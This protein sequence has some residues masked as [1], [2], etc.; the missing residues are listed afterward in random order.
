MAI[1]AAASREPGRE[2]REPGRE[3]GRGP[4]EPGRDSREGRSSRGGRE[5]RDFAA[6]AAPAVPFLLPGESLGKYGAAAI[7]KPAPSRLILSEL[8]PDTSDPLPERTATRPS[9]LVEEEFAWD[10]KSLFPGESIAK[11]RGA[12]FKPSAAAQPGNEPSATVD[13]EPSGVLELGSA[14]VM[15]EEAVQAAAHEGTSSQPAPFE[16]TEPFGQAGDS[17]DEQA[18][19]SEDEGRSAGWG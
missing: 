4:R 2:P 13:A 7:E 14:E 11:H 16:F 10:G 9:T 5:S 8:P 12:E 15:D 3:S 18:S 17:E 19:R 6:P 1:E